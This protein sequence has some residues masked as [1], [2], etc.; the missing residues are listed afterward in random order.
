MENYIMGIDPASNNDDKSGSFVV[1]KKHV[2]AQSY[3]AEYLGRP[4]QNIP[5]PELIKEMLQYYKCS[6]L[7][8]E[9]TYNNI[10]QL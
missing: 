8:E 2:M 1:T 9:H 7:T 3:I 4:R 5:F 6:V 10:A